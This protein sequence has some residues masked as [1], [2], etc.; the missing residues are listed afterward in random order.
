MTRNCDVMVAGHLCLD[1]IPQFHQTG[2]TRIEELLRPGKLVNM[3][4]IKI[5]TGG[6][7]SNTGI[8]M[9]NLGNQV[10][11]CARVGDDQLGQL[12]VDF[13]KKAGTVDGVHLAHGV[14]S[15]YTVALAPPGID[16]IFLHNPATNDTFG[17]DDLNPDA[18]KN[19]RLFHFGY[20]PLMQRMYADNGSQLE[21]VF[22]IAK[23]AGA[24]IS[25]DMALP[26][27]ASPAGKAPWR[28]ILQRI[29]PYID[30]FT[31]SLEETFY[32]L[33]PD[34]FLRLKEQH[35]GAELIDYVSPQQYADLADELLQLG[36]KAAT[37][38]SAHRGFYIKT[39]NQATLQTMPAAKPANIDNWANR[40][41][42]IPAFAVEHFG[43]QT[44]SGDSSIA[45]L[46]TGFLKGMTIEKSLRLAV[47]C[48]LQNVQVLDAVSGIT[49]YDQTANL[50][51]QDLPL[52]DPNIND[53]NWQWSQQHQLWAGPGDPLNS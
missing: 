29:L 14:S 7:V 33:H 36:A 19:C 12:T 28:K 15:S 5:S 1:L 47:T 31:P 38:K 48:G 53:D 4:N 44:G 9:K 2:I 11:F 37:L 24:T 8:N 18:I 35:G 25:C 3:G 45:G 50:M 30:I 39:A 26:D 52:I 40:Q 21:K 49:S 51:N 10:S 6:P 13:L 42:W 41:L 43:S 27:P 34:E 22:L 46:L 23:N 17:P 32:M 16:R 20:P